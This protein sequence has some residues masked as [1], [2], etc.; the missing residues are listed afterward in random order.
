M[1][2][3]LLWL[4]ARSRCQDAFARPRS[5][6]LPQEM[7]GSTEGNTA[8]CENEMDALMGYAQRLL[9]E[10]L[11]QTLRVWLGHGCK[12]AE[13][14]RAMDLQQVTLRQRVHR[15]RRRLQPMLLRA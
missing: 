8:A 15:I 4:R 7:A 3:H 13:T 6:P 2:P 10:R 14:A 5:L 9:S 11:F 1:H 12:I